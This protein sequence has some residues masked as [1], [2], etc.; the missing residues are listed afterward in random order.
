MMVSLMA[1]YLQQPS[2]QELQQPEDTQGISHMQVEGQI[3]L[4]VQSG[5]QEFARK[6]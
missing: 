2:C 5:G 6:Q 3:D 1:M 4:N